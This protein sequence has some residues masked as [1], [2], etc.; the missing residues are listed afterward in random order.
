MIASY[1]QLLARRYQGRL[2]A[3]ADEFIGYAVDGAKRMQ[4]L[5][6]DLLAL[7]RLGTK[8]KPFA[9]TDCNRVVQTALSDLV[10]AIEESGATVNV[11]K[12]PTVMGD[13]TQ[14]LQLFRNLL[15]NAIKFHGEAQPIVQ[16][17]AEA[18][19]A[20]WKFS[21]QDNGI[22]IASEYFERIFILF[23]RLHGRS[24]YPGTGIGLAICKKIVERHGG[25]FEL[26]S[27]PGQGS[28]FS[29]TLPRT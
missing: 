13:E 1:L 19:D 16:L 14:L 11:S 15:S 17:S 10:V 12:L 6:N 21:V 24:Q 5:I 25:H 4:A 9:P 18:L 23:Q 3:D 7:S 29:F 26:Q 2:D 27:Q 22:G 20:E 8:A 28:T